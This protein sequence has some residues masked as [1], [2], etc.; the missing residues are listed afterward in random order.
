MKK[1]DQR[2]NII[3]VISKADTIAKNELVKFKQKIMQDLIAN[4]IKIYQF[5]IDDDTVVEINAGMNVIFKNE[6]YSLL[7]IKIII[8]F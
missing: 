2:V 7:I 1:I 5:P 8:K 4:Q 3:P 6:L